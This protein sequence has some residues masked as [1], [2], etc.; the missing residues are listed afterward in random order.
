MTFYRIPLCERRI[1][2]YKGGRSIPTREKYMEV[3]GMGIL[4][5][6]ERE[7]DI[8]LNQIKKASRVKHYTYCIIEAANVEEAIRKFYGEWKGAKV[9]GKSIASRAL[10]IDRTRRIIA[11]P[12]CDLLHQGKKEG[13]FVCG[14][15][16]EDIDYDSGLF[17]MCIL[18]G[19]DLPD[20]YCGLSNYF[21]VGWVNFPSTIRKTAKRVV[22]YGVGYRFVD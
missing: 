10:R 16:K 12:H 2:L 15:P 20:G 11:L 9:G 21:P 14:D 4:V 19:A 22:V 7:K 1:T 3:D 6:Y 17:G 5:R 18:D 13:R 8:D